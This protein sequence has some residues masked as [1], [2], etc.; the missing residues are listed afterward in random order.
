MPLE[1]N[2]PMPCDLAP[3]AC[4]TPYKVSCMPHTFKSPIFMHNNPLYES[5]NLEIP[6]YIVDEAQVHAPYVSS[7]ESPTISLGRFDM[8]L[9]THVHAHIDVSDA[10]PSVG[11]IMTYVDLCHDIPTD[12]FSF[13]FVFFFFGISS[14]NDKSFLCAFLLL[15]FFFAYSLL[16][17]YVL[18]SAF[19][20][21]EFDKL[22]RSL[23]H[24]LLKK[25]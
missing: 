19:T 15:V 22:L 11:H 5:R 8:P 24:Y 9:T 1:H 20:G 18:I 6:A 2:L 7:I 16:I 14:Y 4:E 13:L 25:V 17:Y 10:L 21:S 12:S 23:T 3:L